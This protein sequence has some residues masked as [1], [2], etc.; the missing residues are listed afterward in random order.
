MD[1]VQYA[2]EFLEMQVPGDWHI[3]HPAQFNV[4][5]FSPGDPEKGR[6]TMAVGV[7]SLQP[8]VTAE[9]IARQTVEK[10]KEGYPAFS[11]TGSEDFPSEIGEAYSNVYTWKPGDADVLVSQRQVFLKVDGRLYTFTLSAN[12]EQESAYMDTMLDMLESVRVVQ[13]V[14]Q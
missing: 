5:F 9:D 6:G 13:Q 12:G 4:I 7:R 10:Q 1:W 11:M 2:G 3:R 8:K 14:T